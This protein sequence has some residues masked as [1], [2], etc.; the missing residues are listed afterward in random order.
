MLDISNIY[1]STDVKLA[2]GHLKRWVQ[3]SSPYSRNISEFL[4]K[5]YSKKRYLRDTWI[6]KSDGEKRSNKRDKEGA[7]SEVRGNWEEYNILKSK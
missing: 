1:C 5:W 3:G 6:W 4:H 2:G 7:V